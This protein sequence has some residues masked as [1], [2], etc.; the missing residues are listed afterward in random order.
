MLNPIN[1]DAAWAPFEH[2]AENIAMGN[3][4]MVEAWRKTMPLI[5][6][7][8]WDGLPVPVRE[9]ALDGWI[10]GGQAT[11]LTGPGASGKSLLTQQLCTCIALG[12]PFLGVEVKQ[13]VALYIT[14]EDDQLALH[15]RQKAICEAM[16][17]PMSA[18]KGK[19]HLVS[20]AGHTDT[21]LATHGHAQV[22]DDFGNTS[23]SMQTTPRWQALVGMSRAIGARFIGLDNVA[24][25]FAGNENIRHDVAQF[26]NL[27]NKLAMTVNGS[28]LFIGHPNKAGDSFSG[29]TAWENQ[30][31]SRL[32]LETPKDSDGSVNDPDARVLSRQKSNYAR[33][34][35]TLA[36]RWHHMAY[37]R[38]RDL[39]AD[40]AKDLA[41]T[42]Q[43]SAENAAFLRCLAAAT[44]NS[45]AV[46]H[47][48]GVN[49]APT[50]FAKMTEGRQFSRKA[51]EAAF[52]RL[53]HLGRIQLN[54]ELW[55]LPNRH[56][57]VGIKDAEKC[58][59]PPAPTLRAD[60]RHAPSQVIENTCATVRAPTPLYTTYN[61]GQAHG[62]PAPNDDGIEW[63]T[64]GEDGE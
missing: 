34:G 27:L 37:V 23:E 33:N 39:P 63:D 29:S 1:D 43:A 19:L 26:V 7:S 61:K 18:L 10:P 30:V 54:Q 6:P 32:F 56:M 50:V 58:A 24:H 20:L 60:P 15:E 13:T 36:F 41:L 51:Y 35:E 44:A 49:Y 38:D 46:S 3:S 53:L 12:L 52:E 62:P 22:K 16:G 59:N 40:E 45:R 28:V 57:A 42:M 17:V 48:P 4:G 47:N 25:L 11:Y 55:K 9:W 64:S 21:E 31:R 2:A 8:A 5:D 14:C